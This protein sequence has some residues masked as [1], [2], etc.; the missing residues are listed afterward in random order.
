[1]NGMSM[2]SRI[3]F[4]AAVVMAGVA[5]LEKVV[6]FAGYT[7]SFLGNYGPS[8]LLELAAVALLFVIAMQLREIKL[9]GKSLG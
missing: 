9:S 5:V 1:M 8:R 2:A 7:M 4:A 3:L 6:N